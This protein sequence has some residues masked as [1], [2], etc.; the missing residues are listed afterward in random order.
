M[1]EWNWKFGV[2]EQKKGCCRRRAFSEQA[3]NFHV[4]GRTGTPSVSDNW[5]TRDL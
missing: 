2:T 5:K 3:L 4:L 1:T